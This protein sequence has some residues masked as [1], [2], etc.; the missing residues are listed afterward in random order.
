MNVKTAS[1]HVQN[2]HPAVTEFP[3]F[4]VQSHRA[5]SASVRDSNM[6][7]WTCAKLVFC[8]IWGQKVTSDDLKA[9][10]KYD[11]AMVY[12]LTFVLVFL[13]GV[14]VAL[15]GTLMPNISMFLGLTS[16]HTHPPHR[17]RL[18]SDE[19]YGIFGKGDAPSFYTSTLTVK[20][21]QEQ[22]IHPG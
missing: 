22:E 19:R 4:F 18:P 13:L 14:A 3:F 11:A 10:F 17:L 21:P 15:L 20:K 9:N 5:D 7:V 6:S 1:A 12:K 8:S 2:I 16:S